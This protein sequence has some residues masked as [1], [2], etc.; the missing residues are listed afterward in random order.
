MLGTNYHKLF[1][2][3]AAI[4]SLVPAVHASVLTIYNNRTA[5]NAAAP[6]MSVMTFQ[7]TQAQP[8]LLQAPLSSSSNENFFSPGDILPGISISN[9]IPSNLRG[10]YI[11]FGAVGVFNFE[12]SL[13]LNFTPGVRA[14]GAH[15]FS[16]EG[17]VPDSIAGTFTVEIFD[18]AALVGAQTFT[19]AA[20][21]QP[22]QGPF[23]GLTSTGPITSAIIRFDGNSDGA[24]FI[25]NIALPAL[26]AGILPEPGTFV[27]A[28]A[29]VLICGLQRRRLRR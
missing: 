6:G 7:P 15:F 22:S 27:P 2:L 21:L 25:N 9:G 3:V 26:P 20:G 19:E 8:F 14:F 11:D 29:G 17:T 18:G 12:D 16:S 23:L 10:L 28:G 1:A 13:V 4:A 5:F 24:P